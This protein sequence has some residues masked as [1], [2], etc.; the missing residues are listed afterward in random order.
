VKEYQIGDLCYVQVDNNY[1]L[2]KDVTF[3]NIQVMDV[4]TGHI[5]NLFKGEFIDRVL[6]KVS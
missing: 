4:K 1:Y 2:I 5:Q 6:K 3:A